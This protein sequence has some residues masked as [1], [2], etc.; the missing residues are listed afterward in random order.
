MAIAK[1]MALAVAKMVELLVMVADAGTVKTVKTVGTMGTAGTAVVV[2]H[3]SSR[4]RRA[5][6]C[7][8]GIFGWR[9]RE[10]RPSCSRT[11]RRSASEKKK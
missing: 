5:C 6:T 10:W 11:S 3:G 7:S 8:G 4:C 9:A 1:A 2:A